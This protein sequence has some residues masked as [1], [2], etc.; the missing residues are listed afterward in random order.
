MNVT[1]SNNSATSGGALFMVS[2]T[3]TVL[4]NTILAYSPA[5]FNC[6]VTINT[7]RYSISSDNF[8]ALAGVG[9][10]NHV[11]PLLTALGNYGGP[12]LVHMLK[13]GSPAI[14]GVA[15][16]DAPATDQ[17]GFLRPQGGGFD[18]GAVERQTDDSDLAPRLYLPLIKR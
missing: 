15:G 7:S 18:I 9:N 1:V 6:N 17:R 8:C 5:G 2:G 14:D 3:T 16:F 13:L 4:T 11:D 12:T 10:L